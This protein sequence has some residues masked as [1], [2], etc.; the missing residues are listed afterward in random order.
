VPF[1]GLFSGHKGM[2]PDDIPSWHIEVSHNSKAR[3][4]RGTL[5]RERAEFIDRVPTALKNTRHYS[6]VL[7]MAWI[8][9]AA[10]CQALC[11]GAGV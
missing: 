2:H 3:A 4:T 9:A 10:C 5:Q 8:F 7:E 11:P 1:G 6:Q